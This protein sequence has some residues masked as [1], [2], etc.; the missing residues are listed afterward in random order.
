[1]PDCFWNDWPAGLNKCCHVYIPSHLRMFDP[2][3]ETPGTS[4]LVLGKL[5]EYLQ[6]YTKIIKYKAKH[7]ELHEGIYDEC[8]LEKF[9]L[10]LE[11][12]KTFCINMSRG[13]LEVLLGPKIPTTA[14][15]IVFKKLF[16]WDSTDVDC[17]FEEHDDSR[18]ENLENLYYRLAS[19]YTDLRNADASGSYCKF[20]GE[21]VPG[22]R[23]K[24]FYS[25][26]HVKDTISRLSRIIS[27]WTI[28]GNNNVLP[29]EDKLYTHSFPNAEDPCNIDEPPEPKKSQVVTVPVRQQP[30]VDDFIC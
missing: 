18:L 26:E 2:E 4:F 11:T 15:G 30:L 21:I 23:F 16:K 14:V 7:F 24:S 25:V 17:K 22:P 20:H 5:C 6:Q 1:M 8:F 12:A 10:T 29:S 28:S 9:I 27:V 13:S 3:L 19:L